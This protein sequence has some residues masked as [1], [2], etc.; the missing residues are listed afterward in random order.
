[1]SRSCIPPRNGPLINT[2]FDLLTASPLRTIETAQIFSDSTGHTPSKLGLQG[3]ATDRG[4]SNYRKLSQG[5]LDNKAHRALGVRDKSLELVVTSVPVI[6]M[7]KRERQMHACL[8]APRTVSLHT[9][10]VP[11][12]FVKGI[13]CAFDG[14]QTR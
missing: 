2:H 11:L 1:M 4:Q 5:V 3:V 10:H 6:G 13:A 7:S 8:E 14:E 12:I 9:F